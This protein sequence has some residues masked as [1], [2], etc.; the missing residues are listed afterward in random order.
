M[1]TLYSQVYTPK[2]ACWDNASEYDPNRDFYMFGP[3]TLINLTATTFG[4]PAFISKP[5]F[6][7]AEALRG[8]VD[9]LVPRPT[10]AGGA[11]Q[12]FRLLVE[13]STGA[14]MS[15]GASFQLNGFAQPLHVPR[16]HT[17]ACQAVAGLSI[18]RAA[19]GHAAGQYATKALCERACVA[20]P[21]PPTPPT[22]PPPTPPPV[23]PPTP[24]WKPTP[25]P[26]SPPPTPVKPHAGQYRCVVPAN[27]TEGRC[28]PHALGLK[29]FECKLKKACRGH[30]DDDV[31][32][33]D[34]PAPAPA[35]TTTAAPRPTTTTA[36]PS[37]TVGPST[38]TA[39]P[40]PTPPFVFDDD[41][42][43]PPVVPNTTTAA[44]ATTTAA[45][46]HAGQYRCVVPANHTEGKCE[47]HALGLKWF[48]CKLEKACRG[49][50]DD[51]VYD[52]DKPAPP[53]APNTTTAAPA[54]TTAAPPREGSIGAAASVV[55]GPSTNTTA[56][57]TAAA[58]PMEPSQL[59]LL[60]RRLSA[61][62]AGARG[63]AGTGAVRA[64]AVGGDDMSDD[65]GASPVWFANVTDVYVPI[66]WFI[67]GGNLSQATA[68][69]LIDA[70]F[71][72]QTKVKDAGMGLGVVGVCLAVAAL[73]MFLRER[74]SR[75]WVARGGQ[76][77]GG[78]S[79]RALLSGD[80]S[81]ELAN[82][83]LDVAS[84][85]APSAAAAAPPPAAREALVTKEL[86]DAEEGV[87]GISLDD[88][89]DIKGQ[90]GV[91]K[92]EPKKKKK[93]PIKFKV[94]RL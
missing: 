39:A 63:A 13:P 7:G 86:L 68:D 34:K 8:A 44:P 33:D 87:T 6:A 80:M 29:W 30:Q 72:T 71:A 60:A 38:T 26:P 18:C 91:P 57:A 75:S 25:S 47:P 48:E 1:A 85:R 64:G 12:D 92:P 74:G 59:E 50:Q 49:H 36:A 11:F 45:P 46:P 73:V 51:D 78:N 32:D 89:H 4:A 82:P 77:D 54:T 56:A 41:K 52:D 22:P 43:A 5:H 19:D 90:L 62:T 20:P 88:S 93:E 61:G 40:P 94:N 84:G 9:G 24:A 58:A 17:W 2:A 28:E 31:Y 53:V 23:P 67:L 35:A 42:P 55:A 76:G 37:T 70:L 16:L 15:G 83:M 10:G 65:D 69:E 21:P 66:G 27:H 81:G 14:A 79:G 3:D